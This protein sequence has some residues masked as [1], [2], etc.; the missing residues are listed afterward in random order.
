MAPAGTKGAASHWLGGDWLAGRHGPG[1][2]WHP[3][4]LGQ[5]AV[6]AASGRAALA[7][8]LRTLAP[9]GAVVLLP[10]YGCSALTQAVHLAGGRPDYYP[11]DEQLRPDWA[12][13]T[14]L[15]R[16]RQAAA[17]VVVHPWGWLQDGDEMRRLRATGVAVLEDTSHTLANAPAQ[18]ATGPDAATALAASLRKV[19]PLAA[20]GL[21]RAWH[22]RLEPASAWQGED[23]FAAARGTALRLPAGPDRHRALQRAE[24][25]LDRQ[26]S[27]GPVD[28]AVPLALQ[29]LAS[30]PAAAGVRWREACRANWSVLRDALAGSDCRAWADTLP[31]GVCPVGFVLRHPD[32]SRLAAWLLRQGIEATLH[33]P[34]AVAARPHLTRTERLLAASVLTLPC[35]GR[36]TPADMAAIATACRC[37]PPGGVRPAAQ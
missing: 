1:P 14:G 32:R 12:A 35:D 23:A 36:Y 16:A 15:T 25:A 28:P 24:A 22:G 21:Q 4:S 6:L 8:V 20:G 2:D 13:L 27:C 17:V 19:L 30:R 29:E 33:W 31:D 7:G 18:R 34:V 26:T 5:G 11:G 10:A 3:G 37:L 9:A